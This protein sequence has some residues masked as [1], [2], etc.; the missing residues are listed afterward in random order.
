MIYLEK[1]KYIYLIL[2]L[3]FLSC[4]LKKNKEEKIA[5]VKQSS[6]INDTISQRQKELNYIKRRNA[7]AKYF[8]NK[9]INDNTD[10]QMT[11]SILALENLLKEILVD[12]K[13]KDI[14]KNGKI[15]IQTFF[16]ELGV[17]MLD[18]LRDYK[19]GLATLC[20]TDFIFLNHFKEQYNTQQNYN[21]NKL[22]ESELEG[23]FSEAFAA[24]HVIT[25]VHSFKIKGKEN[26]Q[27]Y[28][29]I[30]V[31]AQDIGSFTPN[32]LYA[33]V[34]VNNYIY[35]MNKSIEKDVN[36][37]EKCTKIWENVDSSFEERVWKNYCKCY[38]EEFVKS[39]QALYLEEEIKKMIKTI[40]E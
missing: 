22:S 39:E 40:T 34:V 27:G 25:G 37:I 33:I 13:I 12:T 19:K 8:K 28:G 35:L 15:N 18:G 10:N 2:L 17:G 4:N 6:I 26:M 11:D 29:M 36:P 30:S 31:D 5:E 38:K 24:N 1:M 3:T 20:I 7:N 32:T 14:N 21:F 9:E 23:I 16:Q